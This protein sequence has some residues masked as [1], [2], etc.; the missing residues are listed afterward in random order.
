MHF[1]TKMNYSESYQF[2]Q[3]SMYILQNVKNTQQDSEYQK[4]VEL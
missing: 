2:I 1:Q 3:N 4:N